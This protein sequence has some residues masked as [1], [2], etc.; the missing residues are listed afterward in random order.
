MTKHNPKRSE[1]PVLFIKCRTPPA[2]DLALLDALYAA[3]RAR[4]EAKAKTRG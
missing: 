2:A 4:R 1:L 3:R